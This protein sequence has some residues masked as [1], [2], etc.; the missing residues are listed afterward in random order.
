MKQTRKRYISNMRHCQLCVID[1]TAD[2]TP[3]ERACDAISPPHLRSRTTET[4]NLQSSTCVPR[5]LRI[6]T[7]AAVDK[8]PDCRHNGV[9]SG[10]AATRNRSD[11]SF[12]PR[13]WSFGVLEELG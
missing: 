12:E 10:F 3:G 9:C 4:S 13:L 8:H 6:G 7:E 1:Y 11:R 2:A 5:C